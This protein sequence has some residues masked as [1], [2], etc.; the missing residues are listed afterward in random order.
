MSSLMIIHFIL[1]DNYAILFS[2]TVSE[3]LYG[4]KFHL[5]VT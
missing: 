5:S 2:L 3:A 4:L 1:Q